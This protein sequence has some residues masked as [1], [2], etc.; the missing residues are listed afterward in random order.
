MDDG[1][2][3]GAAAD[4]GFMASY[5]MLL[6][7]ARETP[8]AASAALFNHPPELPPPSSSVAAG[9]SGAS[10]DRATARRAITPTRCARYSALPWMSAF[11]PSAGMVRP[12]SDFGAKRFFSASSKD[13]T[14]NTPFDP[15]PVTATRIS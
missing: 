13:L 8:I 2:A 4:N 5:L 6:P 15:A 9:D 10:F 3:R 11:M 12:S 7:P 14:R 1:T